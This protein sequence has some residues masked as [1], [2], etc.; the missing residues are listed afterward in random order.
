MQVDSSGQEMGSKISPAAEWN[1][2][3]E[4]V[5]RR[6]WK[7]VTAAFVSGPGVTVCQQHQQLGTRAQRRT[8]AQ[9]PD[10]AAGGLMSVSY[11]V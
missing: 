7:T 5:G 9:R 1:P 11:W 3:G 8:G 4:Q 6:L 2:K 10:G